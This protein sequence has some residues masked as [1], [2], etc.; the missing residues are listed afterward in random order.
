VRDQPRWV[1]VTV[2]DGFPLGAEAWHEQPA[3]G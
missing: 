3:Y 1:V 2:Q